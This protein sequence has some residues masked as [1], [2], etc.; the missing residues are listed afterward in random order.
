[1][2]DVKNVAPNLGIVALVRTV[3]PTLSRA[4]LSSITTGLPTQG[5][6][7]VDISGV[8][9]E[10]IVV[11]TDG[12]VVTNGVDVACFVV[13]AGV[14]VAGCGSVVVDIMVVVVEI[15]VVVVGTVVGVVAVAV[16]EV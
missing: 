11:V 7:I 12:V 1:L 15:G 9:V 6:T 13:V 10:D 14:V 16:V 3:H 5:T 4:A 8:V 2:L